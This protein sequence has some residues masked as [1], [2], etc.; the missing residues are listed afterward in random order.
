[1][2]YMYPVLPATMFLWGVIAVLINTAL[3]VPKDM[4]LQ[5]S[6]S[7]QGAGLEKNITDY[8]SLPSD[9]TSIDSSV[10][11]AAAFVKDISSPGAAQSIASQTSFKHDVALSL[12]DQTSATR[13]KRKSTAAMVTNPS[14][15]SQSTSLSEDVWDSQPTS[16][17]M[18]QFSIMPPEISSAEVT[19]WDLMSCCD[20]SNEMHI[21]ASHGEIRI[22]PD[23]VDLKTEYIPDANSNRMTRFCAIT[24][25]LPEGSIIHAMPLAITH[26]LGSTNV[27]VS[28]SDSGTGEELYDSY[29]GLFFD[30]YSFTNLITFRI[31]VYNYTEM[32]TIHINFTSLPVASRPE[33]RV[34]YTSPVTGE[35]NLHLPPYRLC[36]LYHSRYSWV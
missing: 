4:N 7:V 13:D 16:Q 22:L 18:S 30:I 34:T 3:C 36:D 1:M 9:M 25:R 17:S 2:T 31:F 32:N 33:L 19:V 15:P 5:T 24:L 8:V 12:V 27:A 21:E 20:G 23:G 29:Q 26:T 11:T 35:C 28:M 10:W 14:T 6:S